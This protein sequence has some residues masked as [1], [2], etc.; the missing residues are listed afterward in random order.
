[1]PNYFFVNG[2]SFT[3]P[4][5][6][7]S[8]STNRYSNSYS[9]S[10]YSTSGASN[11]SPDPSEKGTV[12]S[13]AAW[14]YTSGRPSWADGYNHGA[15]ATF[16]LPVDAGLE[17]LYFLAKGS[18][19]RGHAI[20]AC[21]PSG[22]TERNVKV[23]VRAAYHSPRQ[24]ERAEV[25]AVNRYS[26]KEKGLYISTPNLSGFIRH[27]DLV[28]FE[29]TVFL[30]VSSASRGPGAAPRL[31][32]GNL[33]MKILGFSLAA[34]DLSK[35]V[36]FKHVDIANTS[37]A[38]SFES[39][40]CRTGT[41][42]STGATISGEFYAS[43]SMALSSTSGSVNATMHF[44]SEY[45]K[46]TIRSTSGDVNA[47]IGFHSQAHHG[48]PNVQAQSTSGNVDVDITALPVNSNLNMT[49]M[50]VSGN[51][52]VSLHPAFEG[53]CSMRTTSGRR[54]F[55]DAPATDPSGANRRRT[56]GQGCV[57][58]DERRR[59]AGNISISATSGNVRLTHG[60]SHYSYPTNESAP[61]S[62]P[63][64]S[65]PPPGP[66]DDDLTVTEIEP[67]PENPVP[68]SP[69]EDA[70]PDCA[71]ACHE[72][73]KS[74]DSGSFISAQ[75]E[76]EYNRAEET[77]SWFSRFSSGSWGTFSRNRGGSESEKR[78]T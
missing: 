59:H 48:N 1:M 53:T 66:R 61:P 35:H 46:A 11:F 75:G 64:P 50:S 54:T 16:Q 43:E 52:Q 6:S 20:L 22:S 21:Q 13:N 38:A 26:G 33:E 2:Q 47:T 12:V 65:S 41:I 4:D 31:S 5:G 34:K 37:R 30:P 39:L 77:P 18:G 14:A 71:C 51:V 29:V 72:T 74:S 8:F 73:E 69:T 36:F 49:T 10:G 58:W 17:G 19:H 56:V 28:Q 70:S 3:V 45:A 40:R 27:E 57:F 68:E 25:S 55:R 76:S 9:N 24:L 23:R 63:S 44:D 7:Y 15:E 62:S 42:K 32:L 60:G 78:N 67:E